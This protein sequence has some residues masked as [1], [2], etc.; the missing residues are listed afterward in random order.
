MKD[1]KK[2]KAQIGEAQEEIGDEV[3]E[4]EV[5]ER[6]GG[7]SEKRDGMECDDVVSGEASGGEAREAAAQSQWAGA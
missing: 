5:C 1:N 7:E 3:N 2:T 6:K 4:S